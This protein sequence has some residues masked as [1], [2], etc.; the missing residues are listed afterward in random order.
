MDRQESEKETVTVERGD[1][2]A[3]VSFERIVRGKVYVRKGYA[4]GY[5]DG[6]KFTFRNGQILYKERVI[7]GSYDRR[8]FGTINGKPFELVSTGSGREYMLVELR[9][10]A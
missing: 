9:E 7:A 10:T 4:V 5:V 2:R 3:T 8:G 6:H 1:R